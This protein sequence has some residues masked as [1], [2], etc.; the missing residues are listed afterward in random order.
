MTPTPPA[1]MDAAVRERVRTD[2][3]TN[4]CVEAGA[5]TGKTTLLVDRIFNLIT[6]GR[7]E[8]EQIVAVTFTEK[9]AAELKLRIREKLEKQRI[10]AAGQSSDETQRLGRAL[11]KLDQ[12]PISTIHGFAS[13]IL[14]ERPVEAG[15][16][17]RFEVLDNLT[18]EF[19]FEHEWQ[20][21]IN[22]NLEKHRKIFQR[23]IS[24]GL[25]IQD[26]R[27]L[28]ENF[29]RN[30]DIL[31]ALSFE[32]VPVELAGF[33]DRLRGS[34]RELTR[35]L[36][37][38]VAT[39]DKGYQ[40][41]QAMLRSIE[42]FEAL[43]EPQLLEQ[44]LV[45]EFL[46][47]AE[48]AQ[49]NWTDPQHCRTQKEICRS[50]KS[51]LDELRQG[52][53]TEVT[54]QVGRIIRGFVEE[55]QAKKNSLGLL[56]FQD[57]LLRCR[58]L[59]RSNLAVREYFQR[60]FRYL[61][62]DE[63]QD[64]NSLQVEMVFF[65][66]EAK[67]QADDWTEVALK[68]GKLL[69]VGDPKQSIYRFRRADI[70]IYEAAKEYLC[71]DNSDYPG[72]QL[73]IQQN[74][75]SCSGVIDWVNGVFEQL[76]LPSEGEKYSPEY[77]PIYAWP[78]SDFESSAPARVMEITADYDP[79]AKIDEVRGVE[80]Q[81]VVHTIAEMVGTQ[82]PV[83]DGKERRPVAF[84]DIAL[85]FPT[86]TGMQIYEDALKRAGIPYVLEGGKQYYQRQEVT[87]LIACLLAIDNPSDQLS[88]AGALH[89]IF[90][91][92]S[93]R[94]LFSYFVQN[95]TFNYLEEKVA[96]SPVS[97]ALEI[98]RS[99]HEKRNR[100]QISASIQ[101]LYEQTCVLETLTFY[102]H[103]K[104]AIANLLKVVQQARDYE[105]L[106]KI[107]ARAGEAP[108]AV[109]HHFVRWLDQLEQEEVE[110]M[111]SLL[112]ETEDNAVR[113]MSIH[114]S[115]GLEFPVV[116]LMK[117]HGAF[118]AGEQFFL[119]YAD[120][121]LEY[122]LGTKR[123][124]YFQSAGFE[125][126][127]EKEKARLEAERQRILYVAATRARDYLLVPRFVGSKPTG[128]AQFLDSIQMPEVSQIR[129]TRE[130]LAQPVKVDTT[131]TEP[132]D[133]D[134]EDYRKHRQEWSSN[135]DRALE[136][137]RAPSL[138]IVT[139]TGSKEAK[140]PDSTWQ[141]NRTSTTNGGQAKEMGLLVHRLLEHW[142]FSGDL[143]DDI[144]AKAL[145]FMNNFIKT[146]L[147]QRALTARRHWKELPFSVL[148]DGDLHEG[149]NDLVIEEDDGLVLVDY[150]TDSVAN[151]QEARERLDA[152][153]RGQGEFYRRA[154]EEAGLEVKEVLFAFLG[155]GCAL[156]LRSENTQS[157]RSREWNSG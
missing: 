155:P 9:A 135:L 40:R 86:Y 146:G 113:L 25:R 150:K 89:S 143:P 27:T 59:L 115:K 33:F 73:D 65:L 126:L 79:Q 12:A 52:V 145:P 140:L 156:R 24:L 151:E 45:R 11:E 55:I 96:V 46:V 144:D 48:G 109:F 37:F 74:F 116:F 127:S 157:E 125:E 133:R 152:A 141:E 93:D 153:Y 47:K 8:I 154:L 91:G 43:E 7:A 21:W 56:D 53:K 51:D 6:T 92:I 68:P 17:P 41:I 148:V 101:D 97:E 130:E 121:R 138:R 78:E 35:L 134:W 69:L 106:G 63:F 1:P 19:F 28:A 149:V 117:L 34:L 108:V 123:T 136:E 32:A 71:R 85:L 94:D 128:Y 87:S 131:L 80:A 95:K 14:R 122:K 67:A 90:F 31:P 81:A 38:C 83:R 15:V 58:D 26:I 82:W 22:T 105:H 72:E 18:Q 13:S 142:D 118:Y 30:R 76:I 139:A 112:S 99:L 100:H 77:L 57:L 5:G 107:M 103:L 62:I 132:L 29:Y 36:P 39:E 10:E 66:A 16:D 104:Q 147:R 2:L 98:L 75:R 120:K 124:G 114:K 60:R 111:D 110:E 50:L 102:P 49:K 54:Q 84:R 23:A 42:S 129:Y 137:G 20:D 64:T 44:F 88:I 4:L 61:L 119:D 3:D 70:A